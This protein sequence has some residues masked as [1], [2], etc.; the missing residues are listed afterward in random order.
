MKPP[1]GIVRA[2]AGI[3]ESATAERYVQA[4]HQAEQV[5]GAGFAPDAEAQRQKLVEA[6]KLNLINQK[7]YPFELLLRK[8]GIYMGKNQF[9][10]EKHLFCNELA[11]I[12]G[13]LA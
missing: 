11:R 1:R 13:F 3:A 4:V 8:S 10:K 2:C 5:I 12:L 9:T 6:V 7:E